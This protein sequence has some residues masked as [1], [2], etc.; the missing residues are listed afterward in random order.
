MRGVQVTAGSPQPVLWV[1]CIFV[2][3]GR[4]LFMCLFIVLH[5]I[6]ISL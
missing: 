1:V 2:Y 4:D 5:G 3:E 6:Q